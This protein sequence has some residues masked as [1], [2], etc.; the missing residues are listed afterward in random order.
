MANGNTGVRVN[1]V[2]VLVMEG[3]CWAT[4]VRGGHPGPGQQH[5]R[6]TAQPT[7]KTVAAQQSTVNSQLNERL[8]SQLLALSLSL[9]PGHKDSPVV[10]AVFW[11]G[12][13]PPRS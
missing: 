10:V 5:K 8:N 6:Q 13:H 4:N 11:V 7:V 2:G 1:C 9:S 12:A 3:V